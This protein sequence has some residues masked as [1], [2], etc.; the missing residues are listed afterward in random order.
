MAEVR[1]AGHY[2]AKRLECWGKAK[3]LRNNFYRD[4]VTIKDKGGIRFAGG[5]WT[6]HPVARGF[7]DNIAWITSEPYGASCA[8]LKEFSDRCLEKTETV[9]FA[10]DLC[11]YMRNYWG[12]MYLNEYA[13]GGEFPRPDIIFQNHICCSHS[14]WY[15]PVAEYEGISE[16]SVDMSVGPYYETPYSKMED[17]KIDYVA[18]Q[19]FD[20]IEWL[21]KK[22]GKKF[23]DEKFIEAVNVNCRMTSTWAKI[24]ELN[25]A[26][27]APLDEKSMF[28]LYVFPTLDS[29]KKEFADFMDEVLEETKQ[30]VADKVAAVATERFRIISDAQPPWGFLKM[31]RYLETFGIV[32]VGALYTF[33]LMGSWEKDKDGN[34]VGART[35][36]EKGLVMKTREDACKILADWYERK[37]VYS[38]FYHPSV[39]SHML[40]D[41]VRQWSVDAVIFHLNRGCEGTAIGQM[42][43]RLAL[44]EEGVPVLTYEGNMGDEREFDEG[45]SRARVEAF[46]ESLGIK[47]VS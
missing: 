14:K 45:R 24:C 28:S 6:F 37:L 23:D 26:I 40:I 20:G 7:G 30:R 34:W 15:Q 29:G 46:V 47:P 42:E 3:E 32:S 31:W 38:E 33:A 18:G 5:A 4:Y 16:Y 11:A 41:M 36:E 21:E 22:L 10:R 8:F 27:P 9:G 19:I 1:P 35:P 2:K 43:N 13:F 44:L 25:K 12:S 39:K 17:Y